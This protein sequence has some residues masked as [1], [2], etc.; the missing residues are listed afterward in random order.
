MNSNKLPSKQI[1]FTAKSTFYCLNCSLLVFLSEVPYLLTILL[2]VKR[3]INKFLL[4]DSATDLQRYLK[5][6]DLPN[7]IKH[8][9]KTVIKIVHRTKPIIRNSL[10]ISHYVD[11][12]CWRHS[13]NYSVL[14]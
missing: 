12:R 5:S 6:I 9:R 10:R 11:V 7:F 2:K 13:N 3:P 4:T 14:F 8:H 1:N